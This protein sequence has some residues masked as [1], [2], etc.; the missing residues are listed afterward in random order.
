MGLGCGLKSG[1]QGALRKERGFPGAEDFLEE[2]AGVMGDGF[3][4][5]LKVSDIITFSINASLLRNDLWNGD[6]PPPPSSL[7]GHPR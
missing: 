4:C 5:G 3:Q 7:E 1:V 6:P 2:G